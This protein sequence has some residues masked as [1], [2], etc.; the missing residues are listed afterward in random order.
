M[1]STNQLKRR[2]EQGSRTERREVGLVS[3]RFRGHEQADQY[4]TKDVIPNF[5][6][7]IHI[8]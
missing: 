4:G 6:M 1:R 2:G 7:E 5:L 3:A 8:R